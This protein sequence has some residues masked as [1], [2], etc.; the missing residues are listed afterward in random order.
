M[1]TENLKQKKPKMAPRQTNIIL[2]IIWLI[3][4][5]IFLPLHTAHAYVDPGPG[6]Y[7][8]QIIVGVFFGAI[9][10]TKGFWKNLILKIKNRKKKD[11]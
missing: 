4:F 1:L 6:S 2:M 3:L 8:I 9:Y 5:I 10:V 11:K 7:V